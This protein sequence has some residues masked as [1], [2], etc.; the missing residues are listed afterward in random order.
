MEF[1]L[2]IEDISYIKMAIADEIQNYE[3]IKKMFKNDNQIVNTT[4]EIIK[5]YK[6][7]LSKLNY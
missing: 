7:I 1:D 5:K 4:E 3:E 6:K 2:N